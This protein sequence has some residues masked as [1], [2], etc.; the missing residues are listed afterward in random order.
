MNY[1]IKKAFK[2]NKKYIIVFL[3]LWVVLEILL[4]MPM[5]VA[6]NNSTHADGFYFSEFIGNFGSEIMS[7]SSFTKLGQEGVMPI[8]GRCTLGLTIIFLVFSSIGIIRSKPRNEFKDIENGSSD[9]SEGGEQYKILSRNKG[10]ILAEDNYLPVDKPGNVNVLVVGGSGS[11]KSASYS[12]PN[13]CQLLGSYV[14]TDPKGEL[15]DKTAGFLK[16]FLCG[17]SITILVVIYYYLNM[18]DNYEIIIK[19]AIMPL[20][21]GFA[22]TNAAR[23]IMYGDYISGGAMII[24]AALTAVFVAAG[25]ATG[26][27]F[28]HDMFGGVFV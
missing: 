4:C 28:L 25:V 19:G 10:I 5:A 21:P 20:V 16:S 6:I 2:D 1:K 12:I 8:L 23:D 11:G 22:I 13:A 27:M 7:F 14:F 3:V 26:L 15:Y 17:L 18:T 9:W 24:D